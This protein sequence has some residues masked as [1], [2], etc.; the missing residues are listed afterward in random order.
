MHPAGGFPAG[1]AGP[2]QGLLPPS[3]KPVGQVRELDLLSLASPGSAAS[4][5]ANISIPGLIPWG[6]ARFQPG[7]E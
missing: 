5:L 7:L 1:E 3:A 6:R 4:E 2:S